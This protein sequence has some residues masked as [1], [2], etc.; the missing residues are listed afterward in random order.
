[1]RVFSCLLLLSCAI[2]GPSFAR[3]PSIHTARAEWS[4]P[5]AHSSVT[6]PSYKAASRRAAMRRR[7][8]TVSVLNDVS[9]PVRPERIAALLDEVFAEYDRELNIEF[10]LV[11]TLPYSGDLKLF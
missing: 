8:V 11:E 10:Q 5:G 3:L 4:S 2:A 6:E 7:V 9:A 1:M